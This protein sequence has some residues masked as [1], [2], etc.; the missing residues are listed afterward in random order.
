M[1]DDEKSAAN[2]TRVLRVEYRRED[3]YLSIEIQPY[4]SLSLSIFFWLRDATLRK[5][6]NRSH[7]QTHNLFVRRKIGHTHTNTQ[8][9]QHHTTHDTTRTT[10]QTTTRRTTPSPALDHDRRW[11]GDGAYHQATLCD[12]SEWF[13]QLIMMNS[14]CPRV[15]NSTR[16][17]KHVE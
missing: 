16:T 13:Q 14:L 3:Q 6:R 2:K 17:Y 5:K 15:L 8:Q 10:P 7:T 11:R 4:L 1:V 12:W 9:E